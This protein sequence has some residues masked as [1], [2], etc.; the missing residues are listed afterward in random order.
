MRAASKP[1]YMVTVCEQERNHAGAARRLWGYVSHILNVSCLK[2]IR[3][4][5]KI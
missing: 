1:K 3:N 5:R 2:I 4:E